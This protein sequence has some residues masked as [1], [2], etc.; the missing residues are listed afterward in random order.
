MGFRVGIAEQ[1]QSDR[2]CMSIMWCHK[3]LG[4]WPLICIARRPSA[5]LKTAPQSDASTRDVVGALATEGC[6]DEHARRSAVD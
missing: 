6:T 4:I 2:R 5:M 1:S 3:K